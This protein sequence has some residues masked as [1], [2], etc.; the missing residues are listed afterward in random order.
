ML[1]CKVLDMLMVRKDSLEEIWSRDFI[2]NWK[3][4]YEL[5]RLVLRT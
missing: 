3:P 5:H 2:G 1:D 4:Q